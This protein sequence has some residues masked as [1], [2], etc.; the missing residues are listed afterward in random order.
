MIKIKNIN[1]TYSI[2]E[3]Y[4]DKLN[5]K[6]ISRRKNSSQIEIFNKNEALIY[7]IYK[8][9]LE[10]SS[11]S[12]F[13]KFILDEK[14]NFDFLKSILLSKPDIIEDE[15]VPKIEKFCE[16]YC[17]LNYNTN[18]DNKKKELKEVLETFGYDN[19]RRSEVGVWFS[20]QLHIKVCP[21]CNREYTFTISLP[22]KKDKLLFNFDHFLSKSEYPYL[23]LSFFN[24]IPCCS[25]CNTNFKGDKPF[26]VYKNIHPHIEGFN[27]NVTF[28]L[29]TSDVSFAEGNPNKKTYTISFK[30]IDKS[31]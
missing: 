3:E 31:E 6:V 14:N 9:S 18:T 15:L 25:I 12:Y 28:T 4:F 21:Y 10:N 30:N 27:K 2:L 11:L 7:K 8:K 13:Y 16:N 17:I 24:L 29:N 26:S 19:L 20:T 22:N 23:S 5:P 1:I